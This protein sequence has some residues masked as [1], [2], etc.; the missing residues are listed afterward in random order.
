MRQALPLLFLFASLLPQFAKAQVSIG[1]N[2]G[3]G[4]R[5]VGLGNAYSAVRGDIWTL[6]HNPAAMTG[7]ERLQIGSYVEQRFF[8][9]ELT[10]GSAGVLLPFAGNQAVGLSLSSRGFSDFRESNIGLAY[11]ITLL[12]KVSL[13]TRVNLINFAIPNYGSA[14]AFFADVGVHYQFNSQLSLGASMINI[15]QAQLTNTF[16]EPTS[17]P[18]T[19]SVG[20]A[21]RPSQEVMVVADLVK[22]VDFPASF[23][24]GVEYEITDI[25]FARVGVGTEPLFL[26][27]GAG[28]KWKGLAVDF[29]LSYTELLQYSPHFS[30]AYT[31]GEE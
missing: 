24:G 10:F 16:G 26:S 11:G 19:L 6:F 18:T 25:I 23:R 30:L 3:I 12:D 5:V 7:A 13:G 20:L 29:T 2:P 15:N 9:N 22:Q 1:P 4:A 28:V 8:L 31:F 21:Y 17:L 27:G 14:M